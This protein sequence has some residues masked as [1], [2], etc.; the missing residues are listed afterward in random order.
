MP[1]F[2]IQIR[3]QNSLMR[4]L[5]VYATRQIDSNLFMSST[6]FR[7]LKEAG[8]DIDLAFAGTANVIEDFKRNYSKYFNDISFCEI[9]RSILKKISDKQSLL[10]L[11]YSFYRHFVAD[12]FSHLSIK[13]VK[14]K[15][16]G[17]KYDCILS[18]I[19]PIIS[20]RFAHDI[21]KGLGLNE[22]RLIQFWTDPLS[23]GRCDSI[24]EIPK[25]RLVHKWQEKRLLKYA[26]KVV[27]CYPL[28][29]KMEAELHPSQSHKMIWSDISFMEH[30]CENNDNHNEIPLIGFFGAYQSHVR[31]IGPLLQAI[32]SLPQ[33]NFVIRGDGDLPYEI[34]SI[35]NLNIKFGRRPLSEIESLENEC[36]ILL[37]LSGKSGITHPAGKTFYYASYPKPIIHIG[38][39]ANSDF[40][41]EYISEFEDRF[42]Y[43]DNN[44][45]NISDAIK[46]VVSSLPTFKLKIPQRMNAAVIAKKIIE[47]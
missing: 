19:P 16:G 4:V 46:A 5:C 9:S 25:S 8:Y 2:G 7:G 44:A 13:N 11:G 47:E 32:A 12:G 41:K 10:R 45:N 26:D 18:F 37:S 33:Y 29:C 35:P 27:F 24:N 34:D 3:Y 21:R 23:L 30:K 1:I 31:N 6:V 28:L 20:G 14:K 15:F 42:V 36:D 43:C 40:F 17:R 39:G 38:D 22:V